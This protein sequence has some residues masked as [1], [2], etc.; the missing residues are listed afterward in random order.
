MANQSHTIPTPLSAPAKARLTRELALL[1][2]DP[3]PGIAAYHDDEDMSQWHADI[4]GPEP[5]DKAMFRV[6]IKIPSRYPFEPPSCQFVG[7]M[8]P[9]HPNIDAAGRICLDTLKSPPAGSW[10]P[11]VSLPSLLLSLRSLL[12][13]PNPDDGLVAEVANVYKTDPEA[14]KAEARRLVDAVNTEGRKRDSEERQRRG[15]GEGGSGTKRFKETP[16]EGMPS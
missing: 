16:D 10:S 14:W 2:T 12:A 3:P 9:Y 6:Q 4:S 8:I 5:F 11:A 1:Q 7:T 13:D 15:E